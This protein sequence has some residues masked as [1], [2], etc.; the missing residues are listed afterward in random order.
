[1]VALARSI[2]VHTREDHT[3]RRDGLTCSA[4]PL[5]LEPLETRW[6][7][8]NVGTA[9]QNFIDQ[10]YRDIMHRAPDPASAGWVS[11]LDSGTSGHK[12]ASTTLGSD[13]GLRNQVND[14][15]VRFL[16]RS[17]DESGLTFWTDSLRGGRHTNSEMAANL[18]G[19]PEY[20][21]T[22]GGG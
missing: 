12:G 21:Q 15:Y 20:Y 22:K 4:F 18:I 19:S 9:N 3:M 1:G 2:L 6:V 16:G 13:E 14:L 11:A 5:M 7:P 8:A 10:I 17:V